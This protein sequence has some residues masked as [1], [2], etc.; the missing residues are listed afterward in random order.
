M[1]ARL[2]ARA[3]VSPE[4]VRFDELGGSAERPSIDLAWILMDAGSDV[5]YC[6]LLRDELDR[7]ASAGALLVGVGDLQIDSLS[8]R[9]EARHF[10][11]GRP[12][13]RGRD[14]A[15]GADAAAQLLAGIEADL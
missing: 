3:D 13:R 5:A 10:G 1:L 2:A 14:L 12:W 7:E 8:G 11:A 9:L 15:D 6:E 4:L